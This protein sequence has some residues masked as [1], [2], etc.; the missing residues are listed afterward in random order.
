MKTVEA[1][2]KTQHTA[3]PR[4]W[5]VLGMAAF[6]WVIVVAATTGVTE[7]FSFVSRSV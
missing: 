4:G 2:S 1:S 6:A 5:I 3:I 7:L